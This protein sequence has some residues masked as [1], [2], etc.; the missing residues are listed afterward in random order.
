MRMKQLHFIHSYATC[1]HLGITPCDSI[2][3]TV[4]NTRKPRTILAY[5]RGHTH[6]AKDRVEFDAD[7]TFIFSNED[8]IE[9]DEITIYAK[10]LKHAK[11]VLI[12]KYDGIFECWQEITRFVNK[13]IINA[14]D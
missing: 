5:E 12:N 3:N 1:E 8:H 4:I 14:K 9:D 11:I 13:G 6:L 2:V 7:K 10:S